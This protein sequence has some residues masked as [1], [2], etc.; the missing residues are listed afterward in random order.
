MI[1]GGLC[2]D[3]G[4]APRV[5][6]CKSSVFDTIL[7]D[8][9]RIISGFWWLFWMWDYIFFFGNA[10][11]IKLYGKLHFSFPKHIFLK[12]YEIVWMHSKFCVFLFHSLI[13]YVFLPFS[14][15]NNVFPSARK[16][17]LH[18]HGLY[19]SHGNWKKNNLQI[20][21]EIHLAKLQHCRNQF[22]CKARN[23][24]LFS[25]FCNAIWK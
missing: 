21:W 9:W 25:L 11:C 19:E 6:Y 12:L 13:F 3:S 23:T 5:G 18:T 16:M 1:M 4:I 14:L 22:F 15:K 8:Y 10:N 2:K 24:C 7:I 20:P 17:N